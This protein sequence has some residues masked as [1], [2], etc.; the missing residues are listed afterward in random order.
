MSSCSSTV[1]VTV[2]CI[3]NLI[4]IQAKKCDA[5]FSR[6]GALKT[7]I[8]WSWNISISEL[9][10]Y[11]SPPCDFVFSVPLW[12]ECPVFVCRPEYQ[13]SLSQMACHFTGFCF[14]NTLMTCT[15]VTGG[16][17]ARAHRSLRWK[18]SLLGK[19]CVLHSSDHLLSSGTVWCKLFIL[20]MCTPSRPI[21]NLQVTQ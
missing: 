20:P 2:N 16:W 13:A 9:M 14:Y 12:C 21:C 10:L 3:H 8:T 6:K 1:P 11:N 17:N 18:L 15:V 5:V 19:Q 4:K 7:R